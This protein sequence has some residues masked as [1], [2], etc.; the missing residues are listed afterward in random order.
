MASRP[1]VH[2]RPLQSGR[3][4]QNDLL[5]GHGSRGPLSQAASSALRCLPGK[6]RSSTAGG[7]EPDVA[8]EAAPD[9]AGSPAVGAD[10]G[11]P[12]GRG[13]SA[14]AAGAGAAPR[15]PPA[16]EAAAADAGT[17]APAVGT[18]GAQQH[19]PGAG[20]AEIE[21]QA[22]DT[23]LAAAEAELQAEDTWLAAAEA[24]LEAEDRWP[25]FR[26]AK[27]HVGGRTAAGAAEVVAA[28]PAP[29]SETVLPSLEAAENEAMAGS[30]RLLSATATALQA[31]RQRNRAAAA[32]RRLARRQAGNGLQAAGMPQA[33]R[34]RADRRHAADRGRSAVPGADLNRGEMASMVDALGANADVLASFPPALPWLS[35]QGLQGLTPADLE[36]SRRG[37]GGAGHPSDQEVDSADLPHSS[38]VAEPPAAAA[39][40]ALGRAA[41]KQADVPASLQDLDRQF[42]PFMA[43]WSKVSSNFAAAAKAG[44]QGNAVTS[45]SLESFPPSDTEAAAQAAAEGSPGVSN[46]TEAASEGIRDPDATQPFS[47]PPPHSQAPRSAAQSGGSQA[48]PGDTTSGPWGSFGTTGPSHIEKSAAQEEADGTTATSK[49][50]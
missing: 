30:R 3:G 45:D 49:V 9:Q 10:S 13:G 40:A 36:T 44:Q 25:G 41:G 21:L 46:T 22:E 38:P 7:A 1:P 6:R 32:A 4:G 18:A 14:E 5:T 29:D 24:E 12:T 20:A 35:G 37:P 47:P 50:C 2:E 26:P 15:A 17:L 43:R 39:A 34:R 48:V 23:W 27:P 42:E 33:G 19:S 28:S 31:R 16:P 8:A 11:A